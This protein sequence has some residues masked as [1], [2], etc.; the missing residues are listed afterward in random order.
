MRKPR[1]LPDLR[2]KNQRRNGHLRLQAADSSPAVSPVGDP[3]TDQYLYLT[4]RPELRDFLRFV[5]RNAADPDSED[6]LI[7]EWQ[8]AH[9]LIKQLE[10]DEAGAADNPLIEPLDV[11][12]RHEAFLI[13]L[14]RDP[15]LK[16]SFNTVPTDIAWVELDRLVVYQKHIDLTHVEAIKKKIGPNPTEEQVFKTCLSYDHAHPPVKWARKGSGSYVFIS[17]SNDMRYLGTMPLEATQIVNYPHPGSL[18]AVIGLAVGFGSNFLNAIFTHNRLILN[19]GSHRAYALRDLGITHV[20]C[21]IQHVKTMDELD[22]V[23]ATKIVNKPNYYLKNP[24]PS[25]LGDYLNPR[26]RKVMNVRRQ[27]R[28]ITVKYTIDEGTIPAL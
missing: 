25:M 17:P 3:Q 10:K 1:Q 24:R 12:G 5:R 9:R 23:A 13:E 2:V 16:N 7:A 26:L 22:V 8:E 21:I 6:M 15:I 28:E 14:L 11:N 18:V 19:N 20:P 4:G 27:L